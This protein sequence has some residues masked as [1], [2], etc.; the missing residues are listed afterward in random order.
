MS[1][2]RL[3]LVLASLRPEEHAADPVGYPPRIR[4]EWRVLN[5]VARAGEVELGR[6]RAALLRGILRTEEP[7]RQIPGALRTYKGVMQPRLLFLVPLFVV[8]ACSRTK[9]VSADGGA[10]DATS[11]APVTSTSPSTSGTTVQ[12]KADLPIAA[13][14]PLHGQVCDRLRTCPR[15]QA[16][17]YPAGCSAVGTCGDY[18]SR[19]TRC[20]MNMPNNED[21]PGYPGT[22]RKSGEAV[23][24]AYCSCDGKTFY[25]CTGDRAPLPFAHKG[26]C[27]AYTARPDGQPL[28]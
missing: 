13:S 24:D 3:R 20:G 22:R 11:P 1:P 6:A 21:L 4:L 25:D 16:C 9:T 18:D 17:L 8:T 23:T 10:S 2:A 26:A 19:M 14:P 5:A 12:P 7:H 28:R 15:S 27:V